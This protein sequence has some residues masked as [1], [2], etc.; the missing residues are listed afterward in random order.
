MITSD[1]S[2]NFIFLLDIHHNS[3][4]QVMQGEDTFAERFETSCTKNNVE[5]LCNVF[6]HVDP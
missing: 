5:K 2:L 3:I 4:F 1:Y 6:D